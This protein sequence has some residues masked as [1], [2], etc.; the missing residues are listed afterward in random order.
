MER[1]GATDLP[2]GSQLSKQAIY[3]YKS[4]A[5]LPD[6]GFTDT[7]QM[8]NYSYRILH[9]GSRFRV[10]WWMGRIST[11]EIYLVLR[12]VEKLIGPAMSSGLSWVNMLRL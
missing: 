5:V 1:L 11:V 9:A 8:Q 6:P 3:N 10:L 12:R 4:N 7:M 2:Y